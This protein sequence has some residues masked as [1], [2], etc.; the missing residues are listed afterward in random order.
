MGMTRSENMARI[1]AS[2]TSPERRLKE[3]LEQA[4]LTVV[5]QTRT[6]FGRPDLVIQQPQLAIFIDGCFW[7]GCPEHYVRP[8]SRE[9]FWSTKLLENVRRD[10][11]QTQELKAA[12]WAVLRVW[13]HEVYE[14]LADIIEQVRRLTQ[15]ESGEQRSEW[16][17]VQVDELDAERKLE[18]RWMEDLASPPHGREVVQLRCTRKWKRPRVA[19]A[20]AEGSH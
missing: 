3:A 9:E 1:R 4:G 15:G 12:G 18:R 13:E 16:R 19:D 11:R 2:D 20:Q 10:Q 14:A 17:V 5:T 6:P 8:R 7:H